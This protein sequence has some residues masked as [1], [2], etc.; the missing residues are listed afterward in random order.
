MS[1]PHDDAVPEADALE[2]D[3]EVDAAGDTLEP[4]RDPEV[5]EADAWEQAQELPEADDDG[6]AGD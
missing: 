1:T 6:A 3:V 4:T 5:P 2:Q